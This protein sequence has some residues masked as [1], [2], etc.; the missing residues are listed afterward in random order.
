ML[1]TQQVAPIAKPENQVGDTREI[2][3]QRR[4]RRFQILRGESDIDM[5][6]ASDDINDVGCI[7]GAARTARRRVV[8]SGQGEEQSEQYRAREG[9]SWHGTVVDQAASIARLAA[10]Q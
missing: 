2:V 10:A 9:A 8:A 3:S 4:Q 5:P 7:G 1:L 6:G